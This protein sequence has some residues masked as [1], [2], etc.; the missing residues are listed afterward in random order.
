MPTSASSPRRSFGRL[1]GFA[2]G[3]LP[4]VMLIGLAYLLVTLPELVKATA[5]MQV[6]SS[7]GHAVLAGRGRGGRPARRDRCRGAPWFGS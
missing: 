5:G 6:H 2:P 1:L 4:I 7:A 3:W